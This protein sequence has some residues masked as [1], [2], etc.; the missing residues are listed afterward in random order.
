VRV[1]CWGKRVPILYINVQQFR[2]GIVF[3]AHRLLYHSTL[4]LRVIKKKKTANV[5]QDGL[6]FRV[7]GRGC[8]LT[9]NRTPETLNPMAETLNPKPPFVG[10]RLT[11]PGVQVSGFG[12]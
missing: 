12:L 2:G 11:N 5:F 1:S 9:R 6:G 10:S 7:Y 4:G 8:G 3:K